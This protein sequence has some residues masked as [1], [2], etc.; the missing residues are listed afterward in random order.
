MLDQSGP[1]V[2]R[3]RAQDL[4]RNC[5]GLVMVMPIVAAVYVLCHS[6]NRAKLAD[7]E[8]RSRRQEEKTSEGV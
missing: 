7:S 3:C 2:A 4:A 6:T 1:M 5:A 8:S